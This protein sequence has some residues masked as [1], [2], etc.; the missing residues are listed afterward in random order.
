MG[1]G[2]Y[3]QTVAAKAAEWTPLA[4]A[5]GTV[6]NCWIRVWYDSAE[7]VT[8]LKIRYNGGDEADL[9][10][11]YNFELDGADLSEVEIKGNANWRVTV[12][13]TTR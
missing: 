9:W 2:C 6:V 5:A 1:A 8:S 7:P 4:S 10:N 13:G 3:M 12:I 11:S